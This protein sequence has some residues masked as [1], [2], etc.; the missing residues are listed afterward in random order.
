VHDVAIRT[1]EGMR[2]E[3]IAEMYE[4]TLGEVHAALS[5]YHDHRDHIDREIVE[6]D[7]EIRRLGQADRSPVAQ[8]VRQARRERGLG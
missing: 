2:P 7:A 1:R 3:N 8:R 6:E 4:L 5:Y